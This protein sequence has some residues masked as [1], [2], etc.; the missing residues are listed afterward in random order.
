METILPP[1]ETGASRHAHIHGWGADL[2]RKNRP[3]VPMERTPPR[4]PNGMPDRPAQQHVHV[5]V[6]HSTER[7]GITP[8]FGS[9]YP[10]SGL[11]GRLRRLAFRFSENDIRHWLVLLFADRVQMGEAL[12]DDLAHGRVPNLYAEMGGPAEV[13]HNPVGAAGKAALGVGLLVLTVMYLR[14]DSTSRRIGST[15][16]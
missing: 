16:R 7:P 10:P 1:V 9:T 5:E 2:D 3:A 14:R 4:L 6:L 13:R 8:I 11:N 15:R 12:V